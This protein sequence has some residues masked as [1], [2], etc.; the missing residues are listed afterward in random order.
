MTTDSLSTGNIVAKDTVQQII[1]IVEHHYHE[2]SNAIEIIVIIAPFVFVLGFMGFFFYY[3]AKQ[4]KLK[5][6]ERLK[7]IEAGI[8]LSP[9]INIKDKSLRK[10]DFNFSMFFSKLLCGLGSGLFL[11][12][13]LAE[14]GFSKP[15]SYFS[16]IFMSIGFIMIFG[17]TIIDRFRKNKT[18]DS[19]EKN[20]KMND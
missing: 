15:T 2:S 9:S 10:V 13:I 4:D 11:G 3:K 6:Q 20:E 5:T 8:P 1:K 14:I 7:M 12:L 17:D 19:T 16:M 18:E